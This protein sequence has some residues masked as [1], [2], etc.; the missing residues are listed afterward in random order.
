MAG[1][2][3]VERA[4][5]ETAGVERLVHFNNAGMAL[6]PDPVVSRMVSHLQREAAIGGY[7]AAE[8]A[9][10]EV[11][12]VY[13]AIARLLN[14]GSH[15]VAIVENATRAWDMAFYAFDFRPGD[16]ILSSA[17]EYESNYL[18]FLQVCGRTG[19]RVEIVPD[20][21][22]G[23]VS[24]AALEAMLDD[25]VKVISMTHVPTNG[26]LVNPAAA[27][28]AIARRYGIPFL[29]DACQSAGQMPLDVELIGCDVLTGTGRKYIRG[30][31]GTGFLYVRRSLIERLDPPFVDLHA[32]EW[33]SHDAYRVRTDAR[34]FESWETNYAAKIAL[35]VAVD[36]ALDWGLEAIWERVHDLGQELRAR[37]ERVPSVT[38]RDVGE[39]QCGIV[40]FTYEDLAASAVQA[41]L[42]EAMVNVSVSPRR[43]TRID[44][45]QRGLPEVVRASVHYYNTEDEMNA[46]C[47]RLAQLTGPIKA[48][49]SSPWLLT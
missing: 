26:G 36:Y 43:Y 27:V 37:L 22:S 46:M 11:E 4:R 21:P 47:D 5:R 24:V 41:H 49:I 25:R 29:L 1:S 19:A 18:A 12:H 33:I 8:E 15:E 9:H 17:A 14:C 38:I 28:G 2:F 31:R 39:T 32:A 48:G 45:E 35:G 34:R 23:Q 10:A 42:R 20:D 30:P 13:D 6:M 3:D 40:S 7:E 16:R 44:M